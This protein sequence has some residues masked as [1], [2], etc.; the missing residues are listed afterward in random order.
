MIYIAQRRSVLE[1]INRW[2]MCVMKE[3]GKHKQEV[4]SITLLF[5]LPAI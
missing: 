2:Y 4:D 3:D 1:K 5:F